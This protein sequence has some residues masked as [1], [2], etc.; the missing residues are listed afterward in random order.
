MSIRRRY[1]LGLGLLAGLAAGAVW[2]VLPS[3][4]PS[5]RLRGTPR[6]DGLWV[7]T[8]NLN[9]ERPDAA[10]VAAVAAL[11]ADVVFLQETHADWEARLTAGLPPDRW[12]HRRF[13]HAPA[14]GGMA[15]LSRYPLSNVAQSHAPG[16]RFPAACLT[17]TAPQGPLS[18]LHLHLHPPLSEEGS[19]LTGYFS[20]PPRRRAEVEAHLQGCGGR[21]G[22]FDLVLG[23]LNEG[24][25][26]STAWLATVAGL[27]EAQPRLPPVEP[28]WRWETAVS[29]LRGRP[30]HVFVGAGLH[31]AAV[32]V[33]LDSG[34][35]DHHPLRVQVYR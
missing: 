22:R 10:T 12:P 16:G 11:D 33:V 21:G 19:L 5:G 24:E 27:T 13:L 15:I 2:L 26:P 29:T 28:T 14:E 25:G 23:D 8:F 7:A 9:F 35:S 4:P 31:I 34:A 1:L 18:A 20:T 3:P 17:V 30:D 32:Q 6:P